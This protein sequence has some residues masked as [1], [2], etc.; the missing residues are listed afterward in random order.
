MPKNQIPSSSAFAGGLKVTF[1]MFL[2]RKG[3]G[4]TL[5]ANK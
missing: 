2:A 5:N 1:S 3:C 4:G